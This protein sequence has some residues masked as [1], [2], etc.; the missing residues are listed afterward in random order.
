MPVIGFIDPRSLET[1]REELAAFHRGLAETG[2][3]EGRNVAI[4]YRWA[5]NQIDR[6]PAMASDL[7][8]DRVAVIAATGGTPG[9]PAQCEVPPCPLFG[10][11]VKKRG[12]D[13]IGACC[14]SEPAS[15]VNHLPGQSLQVVEQVVDGLHC[16]LLVSGNHLLGDGA[17]Q[18]RGG[19]EA[20]RWLVGP[21][22]TT[23]LRLKDPHRA[24]EDTW[25]RGGMAAWGNRA[26]DWLGAP[27][28]GADEQHGD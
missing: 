3:V 27:H 21:P 18:L 26:A 4:E 10:G 19:R 7:V 13:E 22:E 8:R 11:S 1:T 24:C 14:T 9:L 2:Y 28:R 6:L 25:R 23:C 15:A 16:P 17:V 20:F 12:H 5:D